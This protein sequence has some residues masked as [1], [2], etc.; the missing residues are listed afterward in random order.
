MVSQVQTSFILLFGLAVHSAFAD[1]GPRSTSAAAARW[2]KPQDNFVGNDFLNGFDFY[3]DS[4]PT[5]GRVK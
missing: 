3:S 2:Y 4:D 5:H 1:V